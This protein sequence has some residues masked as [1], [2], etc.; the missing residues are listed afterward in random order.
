M[1]QRVQE[2]YQTEYRAFQSFA[3]PLQALAKTKAQ[4]LA[5]IQETTDV[6]SEFG[7]GLLSV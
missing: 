4:Y 2:A 7:I 6:L 3:A 1:L 5:Q